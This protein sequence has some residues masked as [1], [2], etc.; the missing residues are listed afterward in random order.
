MS[1]VVAVPEVVAAAATDLAGIGSTLNAANV[2]AA[3][4]T[5]GVLAAGADEVSA[6]VAALFSAHARTYRA[7]STQVAGFHAQFVQAHARA[8]STYATA[9][10]ANASPSAAVQQDVLGAINVPSRHRSAGAPTTRSSR[11]HPPDAGSSFS[12][13]SRR[14]GPSESS[15]PFDSS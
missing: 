3:V 8:G 13:T 7:L 6:A 2:A 10:A 1:Y 9:E 11:K 12:P 5:M 14:A 4:P 15:D